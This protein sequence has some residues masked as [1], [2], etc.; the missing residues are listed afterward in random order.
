M[1]YCG[2]NLQMCRC[3]CVCVCVWLYYA[4]VCSIYACVD[5]LING[6]LLR[7]TPRLVASRPIP[8]SSSQSSP[9]SC[10]TNRSRCDQPTLRQWWC[11]RKP[12]QQFNTYKHVVIYLFIFMCILKWR[13]YTI[14]D[15]WLCVWVCGDD[16]AYLVGHFGS[17][18]FISNHNAG[19]NGDQAQS[20][21]ELHFITSFKRPITRLCD[22]TARQ[23][24]IE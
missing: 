11:Q 5:A 4:S 9:Q 22:R 6:A 13:R 2:S 1:N 19:R 8:W 14:M 18:A 10:Q 16:V 20:Q 17:F 3:M 12:T 24:E 15:A 21:L 23:R 7:L